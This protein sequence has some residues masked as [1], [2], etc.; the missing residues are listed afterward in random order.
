MYYPIKNYRWCT[1]GPLSIMGNNYPCMFPIYML[2]VSTTGDLAHLQ[3]PDL[4]GETWP[5]CRTSDLQGERM[6]ICRTSW[7]FSLLKGSQEN[8]LTCFYMHFLFIF[9]FVGASLIKICKYTH[10]KA[11]WCTPKV[12]WKVNY[13][14]VD[15]PSYEM[16][17]A[18]QSSL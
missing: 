5:I 8:S 6:L 17:I 11:S 9:L 10:F 16:N 18:Q 4:Q 13:R 3:L 7:L 14:V 12:G 2:R 15:R 1:G